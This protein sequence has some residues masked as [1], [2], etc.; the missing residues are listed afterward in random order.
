MEDIPLEM[1]DRVAA[2]I[3]DGATW[4]SFRGVCTV[5]RNSP[6]EPLI[7]FFTIIT[8][9]ETVWE[10]ADLLAAKPSFGSLCRE[11]IW[12]DEAPPSPSLAFMGA[13]RRDTAPSGDTAKTS[14]M[15]GIITLS[16]LGSVRI[17]VQGE[18]STHGHALE[19]MITALGKVP[20]LSKFDIQYDRHAGHEEIV[21]SV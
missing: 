8:G 13:H 5:F 18:N 9:E 7:Q 6:S 3:T 10:L 1:L 20:T 15:P 11:L 19:A 21:A 14:M 12:D 17:R 16:G 2:E 4:R